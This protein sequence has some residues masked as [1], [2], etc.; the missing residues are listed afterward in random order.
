MVNSGKA[1]HEI[2]SYHRHNMK[3]HYLDWGNAPR[4]YKSYPKLK[5][6]SL[7]SS[8]RCPPKNLWEILDQPPETGA[9]TGLDLGVLSDVLLLAYTL[10]A[11]RQLATQ[12]MLYRSVPSAGALYPT[13]LYVHAR[14]VPGLIPGVFHYD[15]HDFSLKQL[16]SGA[17]APCGDTARMKLSSSSIAASILLSGIFFR[18]SWK[19]RTRAFRYV[20]LDSGHLVENIVLA[21][22]LYGLAHSVH[23]EFD[24]DRMHRLVGV[25]GRREA[26]FACIHLWQ[27]GPPT[28]KPEGQPVVEDLAL[29]AVI[30]DAGRVSPR[31]VHDE[32]ITRIYR[33]GSTIQTDTTVGERS[34]VTD[35]KSQGG[36]AIE[37][38][39]EPEA[40][41]SYAKSVISRR[42]RR[43]FTATPYPRSH[44][45]RLLSMMCSPMS[46]YPENSEIT[47]GFL[48]G[49]V[50]GVEPGFY[51][52]DQAER[53][54]RL[55]KAGNL[56]QKM[57]A[58][59]LDQKWLRQAAVHFVFLANLAETDRRFGP[60]G[61]RYDM[62]NAGR[63]GQ[64][65]YLG[66][67]AMGDGC[68]GIGALYDQE[69]RDLLSLNDD[70]FLMY[71]VAVGQIK[72]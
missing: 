56:N 15:I 28:Q 16:R 30:L 58:V 9:P 50:D 6:T 62:I 11:K 4:P 26:C 63:M 22:R 65:L 53:R 72:K 64:R 34:Q 43:N 61:Y 37:R 59:C 21:L 45:M 33:L 47:M 52:V 69:A 1:Y 8:D 23:Y 19:Y 68:C 49:Q 54:C 29:D 38:L 46:R 51:L 20:P 31:E 7:D 5:R 57:A 18:S 42:S 70:S 27:Q 12:T 35:R 48:A 10:T 39:S 17:S 66:A 3:P 13:E 32:T 25:D 40:V 71:L 55:M 24:D 2:T 36:F 44:F 14:K 41:M 67:T 60:R